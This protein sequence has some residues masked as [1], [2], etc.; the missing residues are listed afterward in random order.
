ME[1]KIRIEFLGHACFKLYFN[2]YSVVIDPYE[3]GYV[4][5]LSDLNESA[6]MVL[7]SHEHGDHNA[8]DEISIDGIAVDAP[9]TLSVIDSYHDE[10]KGAKRGMNK[11]HIFRYGD[12]K[13]AHMGDIGCSLTDEQLMPLKNAD[14]L[15]IPVGGTYTVDAE[16]AADIV[17]VISPGT[18]IPM[19][20]RGETFGFDNIGKVDKF[21]QLVPNAVVLTPKYSA[22]EG[23][24]IFEL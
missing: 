7:C 9:F 13:I 22:E 8:A 17:R 3:K 24:C 12:Y 18:V 21:T 16:G 14:A 23:E 4:P 10:V 15:L 11:I 6:A 2:D 5:G 1:R 19:H 20:Y